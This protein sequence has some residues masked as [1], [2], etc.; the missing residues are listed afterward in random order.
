MT[1]QPERGGRW[2]KL[3][4]TGT[5]V[6]AALGLLVLVTVFVAMAVPRASISART[7]AL[8]D[9]LTALPST[10]RAVIAS[11]DYGSFREV[12]GAGDIAGLI[13][14]SKQQQ[15]R[16]LLA[17]QAPIEPARSWTDLNTGTLPTGGAAKS[18]YYGSSPPVFQ[19]S[20]RDALAKNSKLLTGTWPARATHDHGTTVLTAV[21]TPATATRFSLKVGS[22]LG[23]GPGLAISISGIV[24]P[25]V[26]SSVFWQQLGGQL[27]PFFTK[28]KDNGYWTGGAF[29]GAAEAS[30]MLTRADFNT[31]VVTWVYPL[32]LS[33]ISADSAAGALLRLDSAMAATSATLP[34]PPDGTGITLGVNSGASPVLSAFISAQDAINSILS[35][36]F[37]S[38]AALGIVV[39][40]LCTQLLVARRAEEF[41]LMRARGATPKQIS[42]LVFRAGAL[43][44]TPAAIAAVGIALIVTPGGDAALAWWLAAATAVTGLVGPAVL[45][46][47]RAR[48]ARSATGRARAPHRVTALRRL[49]VEA[50]LTCLAVAGLIVLRQEGLSTSGSLNALASAAPILVAVPVAIVVVRLSPIVLSWLQRLAG[51]SRGV[52]AYAGLVRGAQLT[53]TAVLPVFALV[54]ALT[55]VA[56]GFTVRTAI[57]NGQEAAAWAQTGGDA[58]VGAA[59]SDIALTVPAQRA[60]ASVRGVR[61]VA[62][63]AELPG[64]NGPVQSL[65]STI[66]VA[67]VNPHQYAAVLANSPALPFPAG[68]LAR[69][70]GHVRILPVI[71]SP[72]AAALLHASGYVASVN[73]NIVHVAVR[74]QLDSTP[75]APA[76]APF[77]ILPLWAVPSPPP[78]TMMLLSGPRIDQAELKHVVARNAPDA[79]VAS[80]QAVQA[81]LAAEPLPK[82]A[83]LTYAQ[84]SAA[85]A[86]FSALVVLIAL[87]LG[88]HTRE[89]VDARLATMGLSDLQARQVGVVEAVP[90]IAAA[91]IGGVAAATALIPLI[92]PALNLS[93]FTGAPG[94]VHIVPDI[95]ALT[96]GAAGLVVLALATLAGQAAAAHRR[97]IARSLRVGE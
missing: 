16:T 19:L 61:L 90:F 27:A 21:V 64:A 68:A 92:A 8:Q 34:V 4:G 1:R 81:G 59:N 57:R 63:V 97:G 22:H 58:V 82:A 28:T 69:P 60:I 46:A 15:A 25:V 95:N 5:G 84:G 14:T 42:W 30:A 13:A 74:G 88:A 6:S 67:I 91:A 55:I 18:S 31:A 52:V 51:R 36:L 9:T 85:A 26:P 77:M 79:L 38:L 66:N 83:Y 70:A 87:L 50:T 48:D 37:V 17:G 11:I 39:L 72:Q 49:M 29:V 24:R 80:R 76:N 94:S 41:D 78:P 53:I 10:S 23:L 56:F 7:R 20:Y 45:V 93:L 54:L 86:L 96:I 65:G 73:D 71:A 43:V 33:G 12:S 75:A 32:N 40:L 89:L 44:T 2:R 47:R 35:L 3:V 62:P